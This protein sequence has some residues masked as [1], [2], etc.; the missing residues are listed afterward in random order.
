MKNA[1]PFAALS[2]LV[3]STDG[4][5]HCP[6]CTKPEAECACSAGVLN[7]DGDGIAR[8]RRESKGRG[9]KVVTTISGLQM[10]EVELK[11]LTAEL[12]K[13]CGCGGALKDGVI[14]IQ[15]NMVSFLV[16]ELNIRGI[17]VKELVYK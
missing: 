6:K 2:G 1:N 17:K 3:Y 16:G 4:G 15:G 9:G 10:T 13:K 7:S 12:K 5:N 11:A 8:V 14:E